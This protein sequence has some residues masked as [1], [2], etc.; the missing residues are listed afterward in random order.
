MIWNRRSK[1]C[2]ALVTP[3]ARWIAVWA[4]LIVAGSAALAQDEPPP[5]ALSAPI[6]V[7]DNWSAYDELSDNVPLTETLAMREFDRAACA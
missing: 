4:G 6:S 1:L 5:P 2:R 7:Y 3:K